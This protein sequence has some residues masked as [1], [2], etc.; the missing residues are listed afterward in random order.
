MYKNGE[1]R[2]NVVLMNINT[3]FNDYGNLG[4]DSKPL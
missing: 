1:C 4:Q 3:S 2:T